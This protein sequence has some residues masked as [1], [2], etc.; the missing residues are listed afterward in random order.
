MDELGSASSPSRPVTVDGAGEDA[1]LAK[2]RFL[3]RKEVLQRRL[4]RVRQLTRCYRTHYW[5]LM[6]ELRSKYRDYSWTY[7][8][9][10]FKEDHNEGENNN[11]NG[12]ITGVGGGDD[13]IRCRFSGCKT[14]AMAMTKY[15]HAHILSDSK[16]KLYQGCRAVAKNLPTGPSFCNKPVLKSVVPAAC[17]THHQFGERC[18]SRALRRA[19]LGNAIPNNRKP[20][21][22]FHVLVSEFV[23]QIQKKRKLA[24][25]ETALKVETE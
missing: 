24:L 2:S 19:G 14:K 23:H 3:T 7:G 16:Q 4:R 10:P 6:E 8:K 15:C 17:A 11:P 20:T 18:L 25:K 9:S 22:K 13:I 5:A 21:P 12:V 1:A